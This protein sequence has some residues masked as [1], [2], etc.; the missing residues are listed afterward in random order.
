MDASDLKT[1]LNNCHAPQYTRISDLSPGTPY[2]ITRISKT[3]TRYGDTI[4]ATVEGLDGDDALLN[5][6]LPKRFITILTD[7]TIESYNKGEVSKMSLLYRG[8]GKGIEFV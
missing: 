3:Q 1:R 8:F 4:C 6:Y 2:P 5:V 7:A